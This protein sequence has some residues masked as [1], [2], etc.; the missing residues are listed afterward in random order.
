MAQSPSA[1]VVW[2]LAPF[3][4][5]AGP[6]VLLSPSED[7]WD[8]WSPAGRTDPVVSS[9]AGISVG[10]SVAVAA[11]DGLASVLVSFLT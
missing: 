8:P 7:W 3:P 9:A 5:L 2:R 11:T 4:F 10:S 6:L 1:P